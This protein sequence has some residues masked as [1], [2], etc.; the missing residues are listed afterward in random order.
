MLTIIY[1]AAATA[2]P[3]SG[4]TMN[5]QTSDRGVVFPVKASI[6]AGP[7]DLAGFTDVPVSGIPKM[8][9]SVS[10]RPITRPAAD[11]YF[12]LLVTPNMT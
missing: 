5:T 3:I 2:A 6:T 11:D 7:S 10:V 9:T 8:W 1:T 12:S 4:A